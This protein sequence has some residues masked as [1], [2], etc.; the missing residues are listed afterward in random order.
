M[1][2]HLLLLGNALFDADMSTIDQLYSTQQNV[3]ETVAST[4]SR[5]SGQTCP[6]DEGCHD[7]L[8]GVHLAVG[9]KQKVNKEIQMQELLCWTWHCTPAS[10]ASMRGSVLGQGA[11]S[12]WFLLREST[13][14]LLSMRAKPSLPAHL[15]H[16]EQSASLILQCIAPAHSSVVSQGGECRGS[17]APHKLIEG[18]RSILA[19]TKQALQE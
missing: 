1:H 5:Q 9:S 10:L 14:L 16:L 4:A 12:L 7:L 19:R 17:Q 2:S 3:L 13:V 8:D 6:S 18:V 11:A 15:Y